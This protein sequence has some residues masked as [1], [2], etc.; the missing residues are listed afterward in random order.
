MVIMYGMGSKPQ[1]P[2]KIIKEKQNGGI[3]CNDGFS[4]QSIQCTANNRKAN[5]VNIE[6]PM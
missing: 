3:H 6:E 2:T 4:V 5:A 1:H